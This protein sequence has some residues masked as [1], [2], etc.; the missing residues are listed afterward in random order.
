[1]NDRDRL[2]Q[3]RG[4]LDRV[5][6]MP[7]SPE[8]DWTLAG[9][10]ARVVDVE[11][12]TPPTPMRALP[13]DQLEAE[14]AAERSPRAEALPRTK[15]R[16]RPPSRRAQPARLG[17]PAARTPPV[18]IRERG[19]DELVDLLEQG[20]GLWLLRGLGPPVVR[21]VEPGALV[22]RRERLQDTRDALPGRRAADQGVI[23]HALLELES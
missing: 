19:R 16:P 7:A 13:P 6:R 21:R 17:H 3:L 2:D 22:A 8:R 20:G 11:T 9:V 14:I 18:P 10:R 15:V 23:S 4:L 12:G 1:M 5:G